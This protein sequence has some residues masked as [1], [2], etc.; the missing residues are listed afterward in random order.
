MGKGQS[1]GARLLVPF[2]TDLCDTQIERDFNMRR[3]LGQNVQSPE[4]KGA[5]AVALGCRSQQK[6]E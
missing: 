5:S 3:Q 6:T 4:A 1:H 2:H